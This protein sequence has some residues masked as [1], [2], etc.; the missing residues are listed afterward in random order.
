MNQLKMISMNFTLFLF[1]KIY[2]VVQMVIIH[3]KIMFW[4]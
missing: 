2:G 3:K 4:L 1:Y